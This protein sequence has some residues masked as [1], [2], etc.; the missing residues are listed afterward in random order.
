MKRLALVLVAATSACAITPGWRPRG[1]ASTAWQ[2]L[3][4]GKDERAR[5]AFD[6]SL[7]ARPNDAI[8][9]FGRAG[10]SFE[11]GE[12]GPALDEY[13]YV[14]AATP[15][16]PQARALAAAAAARV[17][18]LLDEATDRRPVEARL[19]AVSR[20]SLPWPA[21]LELAEA[22]TESARRRGEVAL[23]TAEARRAG[24]LT[25]VT[26]AGTLG[27]L[28]HLDLEAPARE[29]RADGRRL[30]WSGCRLLVPAVEGHPGVR[31]LRA[32]LTS[33]AAHYDL[34]LSFAGPALVRVDG[35]PWHHH[36]ST[37]VFGPRWS[38]ARL[39]LGAGKHEIEV[40]LGTWGG[41]TDLTLALVPAV[42]VPAAADTDL[43]R[44]VSEL[45]DAVAAD[46]AGDVER[47]LGAAEKLGAR[48][49]FALGLAAAARVTLHDASRP[50]NIDRD[51]ARLLYRKALALDGGLARVWRDLAVLEHGEERPREASEAAEQAVRAGPG[52]WPAQL[53]LMEAYR[54]RGLDRDADLALGRA[55]AGLGDRTPG[56]AGCAALEAALRQ[57]QERRRID[58]EDRLATRLQA[59][60]LHAEVLID[61]L[62]QRGD[63]ESTERLLRTRL[64]TSADPLWVRAQIAEVL[65]AR[66]QARAAADAY[67]DL[68]T[69]A[70]RDPQLQIKLADAQLAAGDRT[71]A[72]AVL[73]AA[74]RL[75][76][77]RLEIRSAARALGIPLPLDGLRLDGAEVIR[78]FKQAGRNYDA[79]AVLALDR[80]V[81]QVFPDGARMIITH[82][83]VR[84]QSKDGIERWG[85]VQI[86]EGAEVLTLRTHKADGSVREPEEIFGKAT[87]SAPDL[88]PGDFVE[89]ETLEVRD[90]SEAFAPG[91]LGDRFYFQ[92]IEAPL[93]RSEYL[94]VTPRGMRPQ[95]DSRA[96]APHP[97]IEDGPDGTRLAR[98]AVRHVPQLFPER[99]AVPAVEWIP[100]V[101]V[102]ADVTAER[103][104]RFLADQLAGVDRTSPALRRTARELA[105]QTRDPA[106]LPEAIVK[107]VNEHIEPEADLLE[108]ATFSLARARGNRAALLLALGRTLGLAVD[109]VFA[110]PL[111]TAA[112]DAPMIQQEL[113]DFGTAL[114]RLAT[115]AGA[116]YVDPHLRRAPFGYL[117]PALD[118][119]PV[120]VPGQGGAAAVFARN[121]VADTRR[122]ALNAR[123]GVEGEASVSVVE[124]LTGW[125]ALEWV[126]MVDRA[127]TD[128]AKL[129]QDFEQRGLGQNFPGATLTDLKVDLQDGGIRVTYAFTHPEL[130]SLEG[131]VLK[132]APTFF[133]SQPA[134]RYATEASRKSTLLLGP[135][136]PLDLEARFELPAGAKVLDRGESGDVTAAG[137]LVRFA[138]QREGQ[139]NAIVVRR[140]ARLPLLRV[141]P[142]AYAELVGKL[143]R[144]DS[145]EAAEIRIALPASSK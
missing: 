78:A 112:A 145:L 129:R 29:L 106:R 135:D 143:A 107:W 141:P 139:G 122:V 16:D 14:L 42:D 68:V 105:A 95:I 8:A 55:V 62:R 104:A 102:S 100:S 92:S 66:G 67:E 130:A 118:G 82:S 89:W 4:D 61:R 87:V 18:I 10:V 41:A 57:A 90:P 77:T 134:R 46:S 3:V 99:S 137:G 133:R 138:E 27:R 64:P 23:L 20:A 15:V 115:P 120:L 97:T 88:A 9:A 142:D 30:S 94:L 6:A 12:V 65:L 36:G 50:A 43:A 109:V 70:P 110:R 119:A 48:R 128:R 126:E 131:G 124:E 74:L 103:W 114:V 117:P 60:D 31:V 73:T 116:R 26:L 7:A 123:L 24:C 80:L 56:A 51:G 1:A 22:I 45:A 127:G 140:Q 47:A 113:D 84:V 13:I 34:A 35:G 93:D 33:A 53:P 59:C 5:A 69:R 25:D 58:D 49:G 17:A 21:Q 38:A 72:V 44:A 111:S 98:F 32:A 136:V 2:E 76:P 40:R 121:V 79:P 81:E 75:F 28:P 37:A 96:G 144:V 52:F 85:E 91:F 54:A 71:R 108:P 11:R 132:L 19:L 101:R 63:L 83:I 125:P 86:P 39:A